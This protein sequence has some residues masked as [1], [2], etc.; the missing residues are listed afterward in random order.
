M[1]LIE[2]LAK[3]SLSGESTCHYSSDN[4]WTTKRVSDAYT[5]GFKAGFL[6]AKELAIDR[7]KYSRYTIILKNDDFT[8]GYVKA[9]QDIEDRVKDLGEPETE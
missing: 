1:K 2:K 8:K 7:V 3:Q 5:E 9:C 6:K 4:E